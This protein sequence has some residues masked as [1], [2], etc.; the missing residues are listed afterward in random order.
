MNLFDIEIKQNYNKMTA[1]E[2]FVYQNNIE[3]YT[4]RLIFLMYI[5]YKVK[6][7]NKYFNPFQIVLQLILL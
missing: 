6:K 4:N 3:L 5:L 7:I 2:L 1:F